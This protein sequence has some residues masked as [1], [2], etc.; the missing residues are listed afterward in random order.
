MKIY[1]LIAALGILAAPTV[2]SAAGEKDG[3]IDTLSVP[4]DLIR[5]SAETCTGSV[6]TVAGETLYKS[7]TPNLTNT[8]SG[9]LPGLFTVNGDGTPGYGT[10]RMFIRGIGSYAQSTEINTLK[11]Y[12]D[13]FEVK[14]EYIEYLTPEEIASVSVFKD[15]ASLATFGM[16]GANSVLWIE[17][18]RGIASA[19]VVTFQV[20][21][22]IQQAINESKPLGSYEYAYYYNQALSNDNGRVWTEKYSYDDLSAYWEGRGTD[23]DW[24]DEIYR[25]N[26]FY[27]DGV[28]SLR[29]GS[30]LVRYNVVLDYAN[31]QGLLNVRKTDQTSNASY[32]KYGVRTNL[33][34]KINKVLTTSIDIGGRLEDRSRPNYD[35]HTLTQD[36]LNYPSN[37]YPIYDTKAT[38]PIINLS[39]T[40]AHPNNPVGSMT[41]LG[42]TTGRT[43]MLQAN[44]KFRQD[45]GSLLEGLYLQEGFSFYSKTVG[46]T[47]KSRT[48]A[49]YFNGTA[50]TSDQS[51]WLRSDGYWS[52]G[53]ERWM[54]GH[55]TAG[56]AN[57]FGAHAV[58]SALK[59]QISDYNGYGSSFFDWKY[60]YVNFSGKVNYAYGNR[61]VAEFGFSYFGSDAYAAGNNFKFY[62]AVSLAWIASNESFLKNVDAVRLL[63]IRMSAGRS[64]ATEATVSITGFETGGRYLYQQYYASGAGFV[65]GLGPSFGWGDGGLVPLFTANPDVTAEK[66]TKYNVGLDLN[67][68]GLRFTADY[69]RDHRTGILT[70][71]NSAMHYL[72]QG[73]YYRNMG[74]MTNQGVDADIEYSGKSGVF[75]YSVYGNAVYA[76]NKVDY[77]GEIKPKY[78]YNASTGRPLGTRMGLTCVGFYQ[79]SD[80]NLDGTLKD[81]IPEPLFGAVQPGDLRYQDYD[82]DGYVDETDIV[83]IGAPGY[84][85]LTFSAGATFGFKGFDFSFL[86][87]GSA[88][89][90]VDMMDYSTWKPFL[91]YGNIFKWAKGAWAYYPDQNIDTR[92]TA[93]FPRLS[94]ESN[95]NN[96]RSSSFWIRK[97][98]WLRL[99]NVEIGYDFANLNAI[100]RAGI[101]KCRIY[102]NAMNMLTLSTLLRKYD[103]DPE[104]AYYGYPALKSMNLGAQISF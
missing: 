4:G 57:T 48:Y 10:A 89:A 65:T 5:T 21:T 9:R 103:L 41:G 61:Y 60:R 90:T 15:A 39:G 96:Y 37:I 17:T 25:D 67:I 85:K 16:N 84:P 59:A 47:A 44:F 43:K 98:N 101:S 56:Y 19:P 68:V 87:T 63:K 22:G 93:T 74:K 8:F 83:E 23:V 24:Y 14:S 70:L 20:R 40:A 52:S 55:V 80:F 79:N 32:V 27:T 104:T 102:I 78:S 54:Q 73:Q 92:Q 46:N 50:Q 30:D 28:L 31:Q 76:V 29:G 34:M 53:K 77:M 62:P 12:V 11:C 91:D 18:K 1:N 3:R 95:E 2:E 42:W 49:R 99:R 71:D 6:A 97:N 26:G 94:T 88:G 33:D 64:G 75:R 82:G 69:F 58:N 66:S 51:T 100:R 72:A 38:D 7:A 35:L 36:V 45:L 13:G 86:I 81:G